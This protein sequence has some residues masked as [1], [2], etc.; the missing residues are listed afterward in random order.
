MFETILTEAQAWKHAGF[1]YASYIVTLG[2]VG[3][4]TWWIF[5][6]EKA[7]HD[8]LEKMKRRMEKGS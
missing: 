7:Q 4:L 6:D 8:R 5:H 1:I 2:G 3:L